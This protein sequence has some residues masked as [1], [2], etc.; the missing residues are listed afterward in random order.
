MMTLRILTPFFAIASLHA[1]APIALDGEWRFALD[2]D[3]RAIHARPGDWEFPDKIALPGILTAQGFGEK[4]SIR[5]EWTGKGWEPRHL[6]R[7]WQADDNFKMPFF[8]TP[9]RHYLGPAWYQREIEIPDAWQGMRLRLHLERVHWRSTVWI[10]GE[11]V[12]HADALGTPHEFDIAPLAPGT[13]TLTM[14]IDNRID[15]INP[16]PLA[17]SVT[18][19]TQGNWNGVVGA[20]TLEALAV[21]RVDHVD[22]FPSNNGDLRLVI[23]GEAAA[24]APLRIAIAKQGN[25]APQP[26]FETT[27]RDDGPFLETIETKVPFDPEL[28]DEFSPTL[29]QLAVTIGEARPHLTSFGFR[30]I[31]NRD[32]ILMINGRRAFMRGTLECAIF[33]LLGHPPTDLESWKRI[34]RICKDHGLNHIRFHSWC[35]PAAAFTAADQLGFYLQP[36]ASAWTNGPAQVGSGLP[37]DDWIDAETARM[38]MFYG[39]HP[40]FTF[41]AYGNEP[42]GPNHRAWLADWVKRQQATDPRRLYTTAAG[43]PVLAGSDF[44]VPINPRIQGWGQGLGSIIN[45]QPP[46]TTFDW[47]GFASRHPDTPVIAHES[48]QWCV[49][50]NFDE[51]EKYTGYFKPLNFE[52]FRETARRNGILDQARDFLMASGKWQAA[53]YKHDI[54]AALRTPNFAGFQLLDLHDF[55]GQGTAL[56]GVLDAFWD[57]KGYITAE[58][59][60]RFSGPVVPL[61]RIDRMVLTQADT[62]RADL[63]LAHF[64]RDDFKAFVPTWKLAHEGEIVASGELPARPL[65][66]GDVHSLGRLEL[67]LA[68]ISAPA[69]ITLTLGGKDTAIR[70]SWD[71][72]VYPSE[73]PAPPEVAI[74][75]TIDDTLA[76]L[77]AGKAVL[78]LADPATIANDPEFPLTI[79]F[80]PIF[81]NTAYTDWQPPHTL[82]LLNRADHPALADFPTESHTNWQ[83]WEIVTRS[84][85]FILT[86]HHELKPI[87][88][89]IDDWVTNRKLALVFEAVVG[90]GRLLACS[91]DLESDGD[92]R[93]AARQLLAS[94][95]RHVASADFQPTVALTPDDLQALMAKPPRV[96]THRATAAASSAAPGYQASNAIDGNPDTMWHTPFAGDRPAPPHDLTLTFPEPVETGGLILTPRT[97]GN[98]NGRIAEIAILDAEGNEIHRTTLANS[99]NQQRIHFENRL[100][101]T[102]LTIRI[103]TSHTLP[104]ASLAEVD[105]LP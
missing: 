88:Q 104:F 85:P 76:A 96:I 44:H 7:E 43:W 2:P 62:L 49:Y 61:A 94:L 80:S 3:D 10:D 9:P 98:Q 84:R 32:G 17:H 60:H 45:S 5:T 27:L 25:G 41:M 95:K 20:M 51:I 69:Q 77:A 101:T 74:T 38:R 1:A 57:E 8:L 24:A 66:A 33:P 92:T 40:S 35:P 42:G 12:G 18:D 30:E 46:S 13:R 58:E 6:F 56:V 79:G 87:V 81:W 15:E 48:G 23:R 65:A 54:E 83:W 100:T 68:G 16:G 102:R 89:P 34:I 55:P 53:A 72:F 47:R 103:L 22:V 93:P 4:P 21:P 36:E 97:D 52:I 105:L 28:W 50:P 37:I 39:N 82:G 14:R 67:P 29:Y 63:E 26:F 71:L 64:G 91:A 86:P 99:A 11:R 31:E 73:A 75:R 59:F 19:H 90:Q 78:W 70:N